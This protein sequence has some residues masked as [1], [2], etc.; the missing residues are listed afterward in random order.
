[1]WNDSH[2]Y[3]EESF[4]CYMYNTVAVCVFTTT[5]S[6]PLESSFLPKIWAIHLQK[7]FLSLFSIISKRLWSFPFF[8][9]FY[10]HNF[11]LY[12]LHAYRVKPRRLARVVLMSLNWLVSLKKQKQLLVLPT[13]TFSSSRRRETDHPRERE[14]EREGWASA[15]SRLLCSFYFYFPERR[16]SGTEIS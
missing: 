4:L 2:F 9:S 14:R 1:V 15:K 5:I 10:R 13:S 16:I 8:I 6:L 7:G 3:G 12:P 11:R